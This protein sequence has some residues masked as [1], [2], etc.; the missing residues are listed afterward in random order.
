[1]DH[2]QKQIRLLIFLIILLVLINY[3]FLDKVLINFLDETE[4]A[5]VQ[6]VI[7]GDT[8]EINNQSVRLLGINSPERG[9]EFYEEAKTFLEQKTLNKE[10]KIISKGTDKYSR[11][12]EYIFSKNE[13]IN[14]QIV[15]KGFANCYFP[16]GKDE[17][18]EEC[19]EIWEKCLEEE[20]NL[21]EP[22]TN[23]CAN[24]IKLKT[25]DHE[26]EIVTFENICSKNCDLTNWMIKDEGRK[27]FFFPQF[28]LEK[29]SQVSI[30]VSE[31]GTNTNEKLFWIRSD[32]VWTETGDTLFLRD[33]NGRLVLWENY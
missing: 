13:N 19:F 33:E 20:I 6:R 10:V 5:V 24:C 12:L 25:F 32:Y 4:T 23:E 9:E 17:F 16:E 14:F 29:N 1:M 8:I 7:D 22:S 11:Q 31:E 26:R 2:K 28:A 21:C 18:Y 30:I 27:E 15:E 3:P